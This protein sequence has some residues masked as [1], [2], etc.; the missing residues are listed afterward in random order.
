MTEQDRQVLAAVAQGD[1]MALTAA[2][3]AGGDPGARDRFGAP[4]LAFAAASGNLDCVDRLLAAGAEVGRSS[5]AGNSAL[6]LAAAR[7]HVEVMRRL[8]AAGADP[9]HRNEWGL[10]AADW[11]R[12]PKNAAEVETLLLEARPG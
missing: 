5:D 8:L 11:G 12:W 10:G 6:M 4:A 1:A 3:E 7:G 2:L 9:D